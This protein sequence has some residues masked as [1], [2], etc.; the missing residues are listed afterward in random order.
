[1]VNPNQKN[2]LKFKFTSCSS[3]FIT[4]SF[5]SKVNFDRNEPRPRHNRGRDYMKPQPQS[6]SSVA[7]CT[8]ST[9]N[10]KVVNFKIIFSMVSS[11]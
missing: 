6:F 5:V 4:I 9:S 1:M 3:P 11:H 7:Q 10:S 2:N 8:Y